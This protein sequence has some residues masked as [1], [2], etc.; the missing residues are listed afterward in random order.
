MPLDGVQ[1]FRQEPAAL[2]MSQSPTTWRRVLRSA[3]Q[4]AL[5]SSVSARPWGSQSSFAS[6]K[7]A[8][9]HILH[10]LMGARLLDAALRLAAWHIGAGFLN[11]AK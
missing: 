9:H 10:R 8:E 4:K 5:P 11:Q 6:P 7:V 2:E 1:A 3:D